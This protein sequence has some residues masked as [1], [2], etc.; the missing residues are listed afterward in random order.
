MKKYL[1][2]TLLLA[3]AILLPAAARLSDYKPGRSPDAKN[4]KFKAHGDILVMDFAAGNGAKSRGWMRKYADFMQPGEQLKISIDVKSNNVSDPDSQVFLLVQPVDGK[5]KGVRGKIFSKYVPAKDYAG[6]WKTLEYTFVM[7]DPAYTLNW[8]KGSKLMINFGAASLNGV[9]EFKNLQI[10]KLA[11]EAAVVENVAAE[12][13]I[14]AAAAQKLAADS[15]KNPDFVYSVKFPAKKSYSKTWSFEL[16]NIDD[17]HG[18]VPVLSFDFVMKNNVATVQPAL[19]VNNKKLDRLDNRHLPRLLNARNSADG[20][21]KNYMFSLKKVIDAHCNTK[22]VVSAGNQSEFLLKNIT[23][24]YKAETLPLYPDPPAVRKD[25]FTILPGKTLKVAVHGKVFLEEAEITGVKNI[26]ALPDTACVISK[27]ADKIAAHNLVQVND[28][29]VDF[30]R[31]ARIMPNGELEIFMRSVYKKPDHI[32]YSYRLELPAELFDGARF[33]ARHGHR[34]KYNNAAGVV[35]LAKG[36]IKNILIHPKT[37]K[38]IT[39]IHYLYL[40]KNGTKLVFDFSPLSVSGQINP[41]CQ[42]PQK[43]LNF[44]YKR[45]NKIIFDFGKRS[46]PEYYGFFVRIHAGDIDH[47]YRHGNTITYYPSGPYHDNHGYQISFADK[48]ATAKLNKSLYDFPFWQDIYQMPF[49]SAAV[50]EKG[51][52]LILPGWKQRAPGFKTYQTN[53]K[54]PGS[55]GVFVPQG[56]SVYTLPIEPGIYMGSLTVGHTDKAVENLSIKCNGETVAENVSVKADNFRQIFFSVYV[57]SPAKQAVLEFDGKNY[58]VNQLVLRNTM[59]EPEDYVWKNHFWQV[60]GL[61]EFALAVDYIN[62]PGYTEPEPPNVMGK[63]VT[64]EI[65]QNGVYPNSGKNVYPQKPFLPLKNTTQEHW[66][67]NIV[68]T[69]IGGGNNES[70][71]VFR[72]NEEFRQLCRAIKRAGYNVIKEQGLF[73]NLCYDEK[74]RKEHMKNL[75]ALAKIMHEEGLKLSRHADGPSF[76]TIFR[77]A[78]AT[79]EAAGW[80]PV[81]LGTLK[82]FQG[83][84]CITNPYLRNHV[85]SILE[86][87]VRETDCD[88]MMID[89]LYVLRTGGRCACVYCRKKFAEDTGYSLP[90]PDDQAKLFTPGNQLNAVWMEWKMRQDGNFFREMKE[91]LTKIKKDILIT[92]YGVDFQHPIGRFQMLAPYVD[93]LGIEGTNHCLLQNY[94]HLL[95]CRKLQAGYADEHGQSQWHIHNRDSGLSDMATIRYIYRAFCSLN[96]SGVVTY[97]GHPVLKNTRLDW[98]HWPDFRYMKPIADVAVF[99]RWDGYYHASKPDLTTEQ[100]GISQLLSDKH[101][102][103]EF[104]MSLTAERL[105][106]FKLLIMGNATILSNEELKAVKEFV[107]NGGKLLLTGTFGAFDR[108]YIPQNA[109]RYT[110]LTGVEFP[111]SQ[112]PEIALHSSSRS[113]ITTHRARI[114]ILDGKVLERFAD[115]SAKVIAKNYGKGMVITTPLTPGMAA[116]EKIILRAQPYTKADT[117][118]GAELLD[119]LLAYTQHTRYPVMLA[120]ANNKVMIESCRDTRNGNTIIQLLNFD[121]PMNPVPGKVFKPL[122]AKNLKFR[123]PDNELV[124][125]LMEKITAATAVSPDFAGTQ[126]LPVKIAADGTSRITI[127]PDLLKVYTVITLKK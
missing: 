16:P 79:A 122:T 98:P 26:E 18:Y 107:Q 124:I 68:A 85:I 59:T 105:A 24:S 94:R 52:E 50:L 32:N 33:E 6:S 78:Y 93:V 108:N 115:N 86:E 19:V 34:N 40:E 65:P 87:Y 81:D 116:F 51:K 14:P 9:F 61:P 120:G 12:S 117:A 90:M 53:G 112:L 64:E 99:H 11:S 27:K 17:I 66:A 110:D 22:V 72:P 71:M 36:N 100:F 69:S 1:V 43:I 95:A 30:R 104:V 37:G 62:K 103:H 21:S 123:N 119:E 74:T 91:R 84:A 7:P 101:I 3:W 38:P 4:L 113:S 60:K 106:K 73:W 127:K 126:T 89:E 80:F 88:M 48:K 49:Q 5:N 125:T 15:R 45:G 2:L 70:G 39:H 121:V 41:Y 58:A 67:W 76:N 97:V 111:E 83:A 23:I 44:I 13:K 25:A 47:Y 42:E 46:N 8:N 82:G 92:S 102:P 96:R 75:G 29:V 77:G 35:K 10:S 57:K 31:E 20:G 109:K 63:L 56:K 55:A 118:E 28:P 114:K 54:F